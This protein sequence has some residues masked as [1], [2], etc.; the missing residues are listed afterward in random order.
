MNTFINCFLSS[1]KETKTNSAKA[2]EISKSYDNDHNTGARQ[3][4][5]SLPVCAHARTLNSPPPLRPPTTSSTPSST[6]L[7]GGKKWIFQSKFSPFQTI[8]IFQFIL[9]LFFLTTTS[10][11]MSY[12]N[13]YL[14]LCS[15]SQYHPASSYIMYVIKN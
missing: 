15:V 2:S 4:G 1:N 12:H 13:L 3:G 10:M 9:F 14:S 11:T 7:S 6:L 5:S 8:L